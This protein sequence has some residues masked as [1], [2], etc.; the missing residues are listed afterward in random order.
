MA[1]ERQSNGI[2][3]YEVGKGDPVLF[4]QG[5]PGSAL[6]WLPQME[7]LPGRKVAWDMPGYGNSMHRPDLETPAGM[8][9]FLAERLEDTLSLGSG[10]HVVGLSLGAMIAMELALLRPKLV[11]SLVL[12]DSSPKFG[13]DGSSTAADFVA[14]IETPLREGTPL[15]DLCHAILT[16]LVAP[17]CPAPVFQAALT[18]MLRATPDGLVQAARLI[19]NHNAL[20]RLSG[21]TAPTLVMTGQH[22]SATPP[23]YGQIIADLIPCSYFVEVPG[24]GHLS[25]LENASFVT[26]A[27]ARTIAATRSPSGASAH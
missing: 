18:A 6:S 24:A 12:L 10:C 27:I 13:L 2:A 11:W 16:D 23:A 25:N 1:R 3:W 26:E 14:S 15:Q 4:L 9:A 20:E 7:G 17:D 8:A 22:D 19:G 5:M 21:I